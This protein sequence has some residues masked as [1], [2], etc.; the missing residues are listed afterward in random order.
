MKDL[1]AHVALFVVAVAATVLTWNRDIVPEAERDL[2]V[3]WDHDTTDVMAIRYSS[4]E[5]DLHVQRR[6]DQAGAF[7]WGTQT[8]GTDA[9]ETMDYPVGAEGSLLVTRLAD[10][11]VLRSLGTL[12][13]E[14][15]ARF[16][17]VDPEARL[18]VEFT[19]ETRELIVGDTTFGSA[20]RYALE[21]ATGMGYVLSR[22]LVGSLALGDGSIR[23]RSVHHFPVTEVAMVRIVGGDGRERTMARTEGGE[24]TEPDGQIPD[25]G[26]ANF[27]ERVGQL[28]IEGYRNLPPPR[29]PR[30]FLRVEYEDANGDALGFVELFRDDFAER[31][32]Y[33][34]R[35][36]AT[37]IVAR[38][39]S[40]LAERVEQAVG[41]VF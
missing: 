26:F 25:A 24:W 4:A 35:S 27:M 37:R 21:P 23:E 40:I 17:L 3:V 29:E 16:G 11:R 13:D 38:V 36:E 9:P 22:H 1:K 15:R 30:L 19:G 8:R 14:Q 10:L 6:A 5:L 32:S 33:Y 2:F 28:A 39:P 20:D 18:T 7:L 12:S 41:D 31:D 34:I